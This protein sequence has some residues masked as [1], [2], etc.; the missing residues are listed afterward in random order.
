M[1]SSACRLRVA[2]DFP[3]EYFR[4]PVRRLR[5]S[6]LSGKAVSLAGSAAAKAGEGENGRTMPGKAVRLAQ[7]WRS[8]SSTQDMGQ[9]TAWP[10]IS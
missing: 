5:E 8:T 1:K 7:D 6:A 3:K 10:D 4:S 2:T 9:L